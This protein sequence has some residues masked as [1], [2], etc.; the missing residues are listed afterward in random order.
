MPGTEIK[1]TLAT[2][3]RNAYVAP[4][5]DGRLAHV[6]TQ[7]PR[8]SEQIAPEDYPKATISVFSHDER[9]IAGGRNT[10]P[11]GLR[12]LPWDAVVHLSSLLDDPLNQGDAWDQ[13]LDDIE[14][15]LRQNSDLNS[16][17][18]GSMT[19]KAWSSQIKRDTLPPIREQ[20]QN[21]YYTNIT[22]VVTEVINA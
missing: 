19:T 10:A 21:S 9:Q 14:A 12:E 7:F 5:G 16:V 6:N 22:F 4:E 20:M 18:E 15:T 1:A 11:F 3:L 2:I 17:A 8:L 13:L